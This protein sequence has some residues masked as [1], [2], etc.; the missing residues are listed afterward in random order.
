MIESNRNENKEI[1]KQQMLT[2]Y[3]KYKNESNNPVQDISYYNEM[4]FQPD[5]INITYGEQDIFAVKIV[6]KNPET[7]LEK[8]RIEVYKEGILIATIDE[9][10]TIEFTQEYLMQIKEK[11]PEIFLVLQNQNGK[12]YDLPT[13]QEEKL[14]NINDNKKIILTK[15]ELEYHYKKEQLN[16]ENE[17]QENNE[18]ELVEQIAEQSGTQKNDIKSCSTLNPTEKITDNKSFEDITHTTGKYTKVFMVASNS[19]TKGTSRFAFWGITPDNQV[20]Q[21]EGLQERDGVNTGKDIYAINRD[22]SQVVEK[23]TTALFTL[24]GKQEGFSL[25]VG[26]YGIL[27]AEYIRKSPTENKYIGSSINTTH[28]RPTTR[29]V[30]EFMNDART[31]KNELEQSINKTEEQLSETSVTNLQNID[32]DP[33]NDVAIDIDAEVTMHDGTITTLRQEAENY[34]LS[35]KE[36]KTLYEQAQGDCPSVKIENIRIQKEQEHE[37]EEIDSHDDRGERLTPE[38]EALKKLGY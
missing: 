31:N 18:E 27:E 4:I 15:D 11:S 12:H 32:N 13:E 1:I 17:L 34:N 26:Q 30:K 23:Q 20:E 25:T 22:G 7:K 36:Y 28:Q 19:Q 21:I 24:E 5:N 9:K 3:N 16:Q 29:Q 2:L 33:N 8:T 6:D 14:P 35:P 10:Q 37:K 38:E